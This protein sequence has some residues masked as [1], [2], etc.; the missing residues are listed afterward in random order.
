MLK[1]GKSPAMKYWNVSYNGKV[2][3]VHD[4]KW[5]ADQACRELA[6]CLVRMSK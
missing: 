1:V 2:V 3:S 6:L 5:Q 4:T